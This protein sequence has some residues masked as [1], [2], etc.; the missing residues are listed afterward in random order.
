MNKLAFIEFN[1][2]ITIGDSTPAQQAEMPVEQWLEGQEIVAG[3]VDL[4]NRLSKDGW[5]IYLSLPI[6]SQADKVV[7]QDWLNSQ[8]ISYKKLDLPRTVNPASLNVE[9]WLVSRIHDV[10]E[11]DEP[12]RIVAL[13]MPETL[14]NL[15]KQMSGALM[16]W[17]PK[18]LITANTVEQA[19]NRFLETKRTLPMM[20]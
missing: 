15:N 6:R 7:I 12:Q 9:R 11:F 2:V 3:A 18:S 4:L 17:Q 20:R 1:T 16:D 13:L 8:G 19:K 5:T 14:Q 10:T